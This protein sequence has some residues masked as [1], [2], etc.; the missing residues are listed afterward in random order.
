[1]PKEIKAAFTELI[2]KIPI[3]AILSR[4]KPAKSHLKVK[5]WAISNT[6]EEEQFIYKVYTV[7][8]L[9]SDQRLQLNLFNE[10]IISSEARRKNLSNVIHLDQLL[11]APDHVALKF[12]KY[13]CSFR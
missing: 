8:Y 5:E 2:M 9:L 4:T 12:K 10:Y 3:L 1:M 11:M 6:I 7:K 13:R